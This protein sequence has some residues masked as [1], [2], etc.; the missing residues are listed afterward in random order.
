MHV[1]VVDEA[2]LLETPNTNIDART[3]KNIP[4]G[5]GDTPRRSER[6]TKNKGFQTQ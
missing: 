3:T 4:D 1:D 5:D 2:E 6:V